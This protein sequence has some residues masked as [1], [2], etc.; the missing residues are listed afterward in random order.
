MSTVHAFIFLELKVFKLYSPNTTTTYCI[1]I[2]EFLLL[3]FYYL[4]QLSTEIFETR[5]A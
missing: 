4:V 3:L 5:T 2:R 1:S